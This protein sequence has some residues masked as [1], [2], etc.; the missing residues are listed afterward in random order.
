M[1]LVWHADDLVEGDWLRDMFGPMIDS[2]IIDLDLTCFDD[3]TIHV[4]G[5]NWQPL[6]A[7]E[8][9]FRKCRA[10]CKHI[11]LYHASDEWFCGGYRMYR[12]FD[13]V[14]R[15][16]QTYLATHSGI[17]TLPEGYP[18]RTRLGPTAP[19]DQRQW[20]WSF[21]GE[22]KAS[23]IAMHAALK[24]FGRNVV[25]RTNLDGTKLS[26]ADYDALLAD[27]VFSPCPMGNVIIETWR[28]Y[29]SLE[30]GCIP[31]VE[32]RVSLD[33]YG[34]MFGPNPIPAF[35]TW[36]QAREYAETLASDRLGLL[37]KQSELRDWWAAHKVKVRAEVQAALA[38]PS[39]A[40][41][42]EAFAGLLRNRY[43][44]IYGPLRLIEL[45]RHQTWGSFARRLARPGGPMRRII[46]DVTTSSPLRPK[47]SR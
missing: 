38:G 46:N 24:S 5:I 33:Y 10:R 12:Y 40:A 36:R 9:Y 1:K 44:V 34:R 35:H 26:K 30:L 6:P 21:S 22:I 19:A 13:L 39:H 2:E 15:N 17:L 43:S 8:A 4:V 11:V 7:Y 37:R 29:E 23:R 25:T 28:L 20:A 14:I 18:D 32:K 3:D 31:L 47:W 27:T 41:S 45:L 42:L 16:F